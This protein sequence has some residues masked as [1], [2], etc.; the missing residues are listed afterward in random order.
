MQAELLNVIEQSQRKG[1]GLC[2]RRKWGVGIER[3]ME[4]RLGWVRGERVGGAREKYGNFRINYL[5]AVLENT[6]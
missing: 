1:S 3:K 2:E 4:R 5:E 6:P